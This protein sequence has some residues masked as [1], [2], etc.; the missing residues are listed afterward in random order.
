MLGLIKRKLA[1][2]LP[3]IAQP[4]GISPSQLGRPI[5]AGGG[6]VPVHTLS[7]RRLLLGGVA[8]GTALVVVDRSIA[9]ANL[10]ASDSAVQSL[11]EIAW[12]TV[13]ERGPTDDVVRMMVGQQV[14]EVAA[15]GFPDGWE[16]LV[17]D[18]MVVDL[19]NKMVW[20]HLELAEQNAPVSA[21]RSLLT[22]NRKNPDLD[23]VFPE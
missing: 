18:L 23:R 15:M 7:R 4:L 11:E 20:P 16:L 10:A 3:N 12:G 6:P 5:Y 13:A 9:G 19:V 1:D 22:V 2:M 8:A 21:G 14:A 17:G